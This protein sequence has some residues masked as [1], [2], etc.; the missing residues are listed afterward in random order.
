MSRYL[1]HHMSNYGRII[2]ATISGGQFR[3]V[4]NVSTGGSH[5]IIISNSFLG[6]PRFP[7]LPEHLF[8]LT[9]RH[10]LS[11]CAITNLQDALAAS[12]MPDF[13]LLKN[14]YVL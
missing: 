5:A 2:R 8:A 10:V 13:T 1:S 11:P 3:G 14:L 6:Q 7:E 4:D 9:A 12:V